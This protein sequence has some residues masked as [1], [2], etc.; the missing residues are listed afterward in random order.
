MTKEQAHKFIDDLF[1][2]STVAVMIFHKQD[3]CFKSVTGFDGDGGVFTYHMV[4]QSEPKTWKE[5][6]AKHDWNSPVHPVPDGLKGEQLLD[7]IRL[8]N[9]MIDV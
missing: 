6:L 5:F 3:W 7:W 1:T 4:S 8:Q 2:D 9:R